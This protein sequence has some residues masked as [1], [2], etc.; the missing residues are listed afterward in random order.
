MRFISTRGQAPAVGFREAL[1]A[2]LAPDG[3]LYV[4]TALTPLE[5]GDFRDATLVDIGVAIAARFA[6]AEIGRGALDRL[7]REALNFPIP[8]VLVGDR[9]VIELFHGPTFAFKDVGARV[10][11]RL[12]AHFADN[13][14]F[15]VLVATSGDTGSAVAQAF[16]EVSG[17]RV[18]VLFPEHGVTPVQEAQFTTLGGNVTAVAV[19]GTFDDCQRL[20]KEAFGDDELRQRARLTSANSINIGRLLPQSFYYAYAALQSRR[21]VVFSVPSGNF[22]NLTAG[23]FAW[24]LGAPIHHFI[25]ATTVN[26]AVPRYLQSGSYEPRATIATVANAMDVGHPSNFERM[27]WLFGSDVAAMRAMMTPS[28]HTDEQVRATIREVFERFEYV[29]D[30]HTAIGYRGLDAF[31]NLE[32]SSAFLATAHPA[33]FKEVV[34]PAIRAHVPLPTPLAEAIAK[35]RL[36]QRIRPEL[37][38]LADIVSAL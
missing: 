26:D 18:V 17:T 7:L 25:A 29:C 32:Y 36:V 11:A 16:H 15:T 21:P 34:E 33:K 38:S 30:P 5:L 9:A 6:G 19:A 1:F 27:R 12:M 13:V 2:G 23:L 24:K 35:P 37:S 14:P 31:T 22:G 4:P 3:G 28:V 20:A 8:I 10:M